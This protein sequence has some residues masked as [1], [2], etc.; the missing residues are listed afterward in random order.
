MILVLKF[1]GGSVWLGAS[2]QRDIQETE[3][4]GEPPVKL[5]SPAK[6]TVA[7]TKRLLKLSE[8]AEF[9]GLSNSWL[10]PEDNDQGDSFHQARQPHDVQRETASD[11]AC[12][13]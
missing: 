6:E 4:N 8:A 12:E 13:P 2:E 1:R 10:Y 11:L 5:E 7:P 9:L 3:R